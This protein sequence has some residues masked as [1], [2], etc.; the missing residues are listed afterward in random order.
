MP[1]F[2]SQHSNPQQGHNPQQQHQSQPYRPDVF[3]HQHNMYVVT[4]AGDYAKQNSP[5]INDIRLGLVRKVYALLSMQ[6]ALTA[7]ITLPFVT[8]P[9]VV[10]WYM[11]NVWLM[12]L[13][14]A[15]MFILLILL[16]FNKEKHPINLFLLIGFTVVS[17]MVVASA[18]ASVVCSPVD[19]NSRCDINPDKQLIVANAASV[20]M[21]TFFLLT[22]FVWLTKIDFGFLGIV[23]GPLLGIL[24]I[25]G[26]FAAIF[27]W[28][29]GYLYSLLGIVV[30]IGYIVFDTWRLKDKG[31]VDDYVIFAVDLYLDIINLF[32]YILSCLNDD[33]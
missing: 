8:S 14:A 25:W 33:D 32:L 9:S 24:I 16:F 5:H 29:T 11:K 20:T 31:G 1:S 13:C 22:A 12:W 19:D 18:C 17:S 23:L 28:R 26:I 15:M 2:D 6:L 3:A 27:G 30:F 21:V 10:T 7:T 4:A